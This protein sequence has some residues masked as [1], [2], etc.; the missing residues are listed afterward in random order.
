[1]SRALPGTTKL[2]WNRLL[3]AF[4]IPTQNHQSSSLVKLSK[5]YNGHLP[6]AFKGR[7]SPRA[8]SPSAPPRPSDDLRVPPVSGSAT[9]LSAAPR[10]EG[11]LSPFEVSL[12]LPLRPEGLDSARQR[13]IFRGTQNILF[14][15]AGRL[16]SKWFVVFYCPH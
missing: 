15:A 12:S 6:P 9:S 8:D 3:S 1:M 14:Q 4:D 5:T 7:L 13:L 11:H 10:G 2:F 16:V